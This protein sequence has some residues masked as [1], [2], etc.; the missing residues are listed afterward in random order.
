MYITAAAA[1][2]RKPSVFGNNEPV[3]LQAGCESQ[4]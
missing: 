2:Y 3:D 1:T 4:D